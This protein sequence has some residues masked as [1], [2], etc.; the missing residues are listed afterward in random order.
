[1]E[2]A[3]AERVA[4]ARRRARPAICRPAVQTAL[5][6]SAPSGISTSQASSPPRLSAESLRDRRSSRSSDRRA[7]AAS[8]IMPLADLAGAATGIAERHGRTTRS[9]ARDARRRTR[10]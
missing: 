1:L 10:K 8:A 7:C 9:L 2:D 5:E 6:V 4:V 3:D